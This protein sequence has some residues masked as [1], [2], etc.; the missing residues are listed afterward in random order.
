MIE[1]LENIPFSLLTDQS[2]ETFGN[3]LGLSMSYEDLLL[4]RDYCRERG[5]ANISLSVLRMLDAISSNAK[6]NA[7]N[8]LITSLCTNNKAAFETHVDLARKQSII[9][10]ANSPLSLTD[11]ANVANN[12]TKITRKRT[13]QLL[14]MRDICTE[15]GAPVFPITDEL[16]KLSLSLAPSTAF[17]LAYPKEPMSYSN[18]LR[19]L[20]SFLSCDGLSDKVILAR[21]ISHGGIAATLS[22]L[23]SGALL[24]IKAI[25][26]LPENA[27]LSHLVSEHHGRFILALQQPHIEFASAIAEYYGLSIAYF[28]KVILGERLV[29]VPGNDI[30]ETIDTPLILKLSNHKTHLEVFIKD[31]EETGAESIP[32]FVANGSEEK[33]AVS[34]GALHLSGDSTSSVSVSHL[35]GDPFTASLDTAMGAILPIL[36]CGIG[37]EDIFLKLKYTFRDTADKEYVG[38]ALAAILGI[39]RIMSELYLSGESAVEYTDN[40]QPSVAVAAFADSRK[41]RVPNKLINEHSGLYLLSFERTECGMPDFENFREMCDFYTECIKSKCV[42]ST[43]AVNGDLSDALAAMRSHLECKLDESAKPFLKNS[44][45]G[46]VVESDIPLRHGVFLGTTVMV[47]DAL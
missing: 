5:Y 28:A 25:P 41:L 24:N 16:C 39:Y 23:S 29:F 42:R 11:S 47:T 38:D 17:V 7:K 2:L 6:K 32:L 4:C 3:T 18:Y 40:A 30:Q 19:A 12:Y 1:S 33:R 8:L 45:C 9:S 34:Y 44:V 43:A 13:H 26:E 14:N 10:H 35:G 36:A 31:A 37:R 27:D 20:D 22:E 15:D 46:I 21:R